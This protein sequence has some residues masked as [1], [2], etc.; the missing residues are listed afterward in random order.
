M[1]P[2]YLLPDSHVLVLTDWKQNVLKNVSFVI[3]FVFVRFSAIFVQTSK[4]DAS[5]KLDE[6]EFFSKVDPFHFNI[7]TEFYK[8]RFR[9]FKDNN[10]FVT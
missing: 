7:H 6:V 4:M 3:F 5:L 2:C 10:Y 1:N 8:G 9:N